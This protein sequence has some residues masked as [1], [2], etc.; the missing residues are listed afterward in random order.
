ME[1]IL[2]RDWIYNFDKIT[3]RRLTNSYKWDNTTPIYGK[4]KLLPVWV[5]DMDFEV[6]PE[7]YESVRKKIEHGIYGYSVFG[8]SYKY[9]I[10][11]WF[12]NRHKWD[13]SED[14]IL[15]YPGIV[16]FLHLA[17]EALTKHGEAVLIHDPVYHPFKNVVLEHGRIPIAS[18][19]VNKNGY[20]E[21]DFN[22]ME[23]KI[24]AK[25][26][27]LFIFCSPH[28]PGGRVWS[29]AELT[30][31]GEFCLN[32]GVTVISDE[33]HCDILINGN[34]HTPLA[35]ISND[36]SQNVITCTGVSKAFN[37]AG[38]PCANVVIENKNLRAKIVEYVKKRGFTM[39]DYLTSTIV[40]TCYEEGEKWL[41]EMC[42]Y[43][44]E[45][46]EYIN[47]FFCDNLPMSKSFVIEGTYLAWIDIRE[48][49]KAK[50]DYKDRLVKEGVAVSYG[51]MFGEAGLGFIR[52]NAAAPFSLLENALE[53]IKKALI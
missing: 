32:K 41:D 8:K 44:G 20:Y 49:I 27:K 17:V 29:K 10:M 39:P 50:P 45:N 21:M 37:T 3:D 31:L 15:Y 13:I 36:I 16:Q 47:S 33:I 7:V 52:I 42:V 11:R 51:D 35:N 24:D 34:I 22:D 26:I 6:C 18:R 48:Y 25:G 43:V 12:K 2:K 19:L 53:R 30:T 14:W 23:K 5:A 9:S 28:N 1:R 40:E 46:L 4:D 38:F